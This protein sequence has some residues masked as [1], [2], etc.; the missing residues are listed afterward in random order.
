MLRP[1]LARWLKADLTPSVDWNSTAS[2]PVLCRT[3]VQQPQLFGSQRVEQVLCESGKDYE[4]LKRW[5]R[6]GQVS[7]IRFGRSLDARQMRLTEMTAGA[8]PVWRLQLM[9]SQEQSVLAEFA[10]PTWFG[11]WVNERH[12]GLGGSI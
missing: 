11:L 8:S 1:L 4:L 12:E 9:P 7:R 5:T 10:N 3:T 2:S 6:S